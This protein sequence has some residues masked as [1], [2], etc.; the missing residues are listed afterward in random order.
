[1]YYEIMELLRLIENGED[2]SIHNQYS[3][4]EMEVMDEVRKCAG[5]DFSVKTL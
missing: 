4:Y 3:L 5:I 1:M 2:G